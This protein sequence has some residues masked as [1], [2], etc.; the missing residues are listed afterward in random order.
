MVVIDN[1][2]K[3][4]QSFYWLGETYTRLRKPE[5]AIEN[6]ETTVQLMTGHID[7]H[8]SLAKLY[9]QTGKIDLAIGEYETVLD[10]IPNH[11]EATHLLGE[12]IRSKNKDAEFLIKP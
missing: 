2:P 6:F 11:K 4:Y 3:N 8:L 5:K 1:D 10:L 7:A 12:T 9:N